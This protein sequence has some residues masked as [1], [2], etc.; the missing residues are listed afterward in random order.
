VD[1]LRYN[2]DKILISKIIHL[3]N[4]LNYRTID[5]SNQQIQKIQAHAFDFEHQKEIQVLILLQNNKLNS[6]SFEVFT[7]SKRHLNINLSDNQ[8]TYLDDKIFG[9]ILHLDSM[10]VIN[11]KNSPLECDCRSKWLIK[12]KD[13]MKNEVL[14]AKCKNGKIVWDLTLNNFINC[15]Q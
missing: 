5:L 1:A 8:L 7:N 4:Y 10:S 2:S 11:I 6:T 13:R 14:E 3:I 9:P 15:K 12:D